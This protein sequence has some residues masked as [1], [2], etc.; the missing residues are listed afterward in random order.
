[1]SEVDRE[2]E[3]GPSLAENLPDEGSGVPQRQENVRRPESNRAGYC[4]GS[5]ATNT[6]SARR[7]LVSFGSRTSFPSRLA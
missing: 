3:G 2:P 4:S 7:Y 1:M 5:D 6:P